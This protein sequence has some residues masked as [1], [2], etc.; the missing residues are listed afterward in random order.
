MNYFRA[1]WDRAI[2]LVAAVVGVVAILIGYIGVS[3]TP[4]VAEQIPYV[5]SGG[6]FGLFALGIACMSW[7]SADIRDEWRELRAIRE[8][9]ESDQR[10]G[11]STPSPSEFAPDETQRPTMSTGTNG[12]S[13]RRPSPRAT[14]DRA[15][16]A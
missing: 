15:R 13:R 9:L 10:P 8:T 7:I 11:R 2:G 5:I 4:H 12:T 6:V 16:N 3:G 14:R 1:Q